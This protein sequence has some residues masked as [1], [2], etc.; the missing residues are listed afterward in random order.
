MPETSPVLLPYQQAWVADLAPFKIMEKGRR[1]GVTFAEAADDVL[2]AAADRAAGGQN[3]Y[4]L[5]TDKEMTEEYID[6]CALWAKAFNRAASIVEESLWDEDD[7]DRHIRTYTIRFP[8][9]CR[10]VAL[11]A[12]PRKLRGRQGILIGD[13]AAFM[14]DLPGLLKSAMAFLIWGGKVRLISTHDGTDNPFNELLEEVRSGQRR[15]SIHRITFRDAVAQGLYQ[16]ICQTKGRLWTADAEAA[17]VQETYDYYGEDAEEELDVIPRGGGDDQFLPVVVIENCMQPGDVLRWHCTD[18]YAVQAEP[19]RQTV[20]QHWIDAELAPRVANLPPQCSHFLGEDFGR[21]IDLTVLAPVTL[22]PTLTRHVPFVV[23]LRNVPFQ[24]QQQVL[25]WLLDY[26]PNFTNAQ[27]DARGNGSHLAELAWQRYGADHIGQVMLSDAW[28]R[29]HMPGFRKAFEGQ[30]ILIPRHADLRKDLTALRRL[31]GV[32]KL[33]DRSRQKGSDG[34]PRHADAAIALA[35]AWAASQQTAWSA[36]WQ[37]APS[38]RSR[39]AEDDDEDDEDDERPRLRR[40]GG[41]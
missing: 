1:T 28:Y 41:W 36:D 26:L 37:A 22:T 6:A 34:K 27:L 9:D 11:A 25:F 4:Y 10:I 38:R 18:A 12:R 5:G 3:V 19:D 30:Q 8:S 21:T 13:E 23:E 15:G 7:E 24:Q 29:E 20:C 17:W 31:G 16:R 40:A 35:L 2:I 39:S 33:S 14:D 32:Y